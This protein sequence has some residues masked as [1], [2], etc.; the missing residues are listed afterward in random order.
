MPGGPGGPLGQM[1]SASHSQ[2]P[3]SGCDCRLFLDAS[4]FAKTGKNLSVA[5]NFF[6]LGNMP[7]IKVG[8]F[9]A[10]PNR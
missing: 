4:C 5:F 6:D 8:G 2:I 9:L 1:P 3:I 7:Y 10:K